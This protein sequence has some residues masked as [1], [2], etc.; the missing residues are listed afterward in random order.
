MVCTLRE[1]HLEEHV[2]WKAKKKPVFRL[3]ERR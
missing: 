3:K 2:M 1:G